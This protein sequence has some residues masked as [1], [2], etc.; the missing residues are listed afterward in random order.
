MNFS[1]V[2]IQNLQL[3]NTIDVNP[4]LVVLPLV[5]PFLCHKEDQ[6]FNQN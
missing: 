2:D 6:L 3:P 5:L 1:E 4:P